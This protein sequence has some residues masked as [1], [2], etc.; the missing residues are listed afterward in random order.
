MRPSKAVAKGSRNEE[1]RATG[2][3]EKTANIKQVSRRTQLKG[4]AYIWLTIL[5]L[6][7]V[8]GDVDRFTVG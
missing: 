4:S 2:A 7:D 8:G 1:G 6:S 3:G 5:D